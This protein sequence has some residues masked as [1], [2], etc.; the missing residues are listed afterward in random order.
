MLKTLRASGVNGRFDVDCSFHRDVNVI[1]GRNGSGK[2]TLLKLLWY[3]ISGNLERI[4]QEVTFRDIYLET[5]DFTIVLRSTKDD[6]VELTLV[7]GD[8]NI[9][10]SCSIEVFKDEPRWL[11]NANEKTAAARP[12]VFFPTFRRIEG[13]FSLGAPSRNRQWA[14]VTPYGVEPDRVFRSLSESLS[15]LGHIFVCAI[16][17]DDIVRL[18]TDKYADISQK[19][20]DAH[21]QLVRAIISEVEA[22]GGLGD[23]KNREVERALLNSALKAIENVRKLTTTFRSRQEEL[24]SPF[25]TLSGFID[26]VF[27]DKGINITGGIDLGGNKYKV[28]SDLL[29]A[30]EKQMLSFLVYNAFFDGVPIFIDEPEISLHVDWQRTLLPTLSKQGTKNQFIIATHSPFIYSR[31]EDKEIILESSRGE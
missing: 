31:Y 26:A 19:T 11:R 24:L 27:R 21:S 8:N 28:A 12:S 10:Q 4:C 7:I 25:E 17:T 22:Q 9:S 2:T 14:G 1:T 23:R 18:L 16:S 29:S 15:I 5:S 3:L 6:N 13:G 30:G 20:N